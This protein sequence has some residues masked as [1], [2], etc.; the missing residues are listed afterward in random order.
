MTL[1]RLALFLCLISLFVAGL[2]LVDAIPFL[3]GGYGWQWPYALAPAGRIA[4]LAGAL[5]LYGLGL[6]ALARRQARDRWWLA[7]SVCAVAGLALAVLALRADEVLYELFARTVSPLSTGVYT[8]AARIDW[9]GGAWRDWPA[10]MTAFE[11]EIAHVS[12]APPGLPLL[13][14]LIQQVFAW[15]PGAAQPIYRLLLPYQCHNYALLA[16]A[17]FVWASAIFGMLL[18][19][20]AA[21]GALPLYAAARRASGPRTARLAVALYPLVPA[22]LVFSGTWNSVYPLIG[23]LALWALLRGL[24]AQGRRWMFAG[25]GWFALTGLITGLAIF[26]NFAFI[27]LILLAGWLTLLHWWLVERRRGTAAPW[28]APLL[29]GAWFALGLA[30]PWLLY[31]LASGQ[32]L[33]GLLATSL[34]MHLELDRPYLPWVWLHFWDWVLWAGLPLAL[35]WLAGL[36][37]GWRRGKTPPVLALALL[38]TIALLIVSNFARGETGRVWLLFAPMLLI[39]AADGMLRLN[40][41]WRWLLIAQAGWLLAVAATLDAVGT[42]LTPPPD[43][44]PALAFDQPSGANFDDVFRLDGWTAQSDAAGIDLALTWTPLAR[45]ERP[46]W[47]SA[48]VVDAAGAP[49]GPAR[50]WQP[51]DTRYPTTCWA[52]GAALTDAVRLPLP[53]DARGPFWISLSAFGDEDGTDRL[54]VT[55]PDG[56]QDTQVGLG[57]VG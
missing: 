42:G 40:G 48:L 49:V 44:P 12:L 17:P 19:L 8:A 31:G 5:A 15:L 41:R 45:A 35:L 18:P 34:S 56:A 2:L 24:D 39:A 43:A 25:A 30:L 57:P 7:W 27:P 6:W 23:G 33:F 1:R 21:L 52:P 10:L 32:T 47:F 20:W 29:R 14:A 37:A 53:D 50:D 28:L 54:P 38:L 3:R 16:D 55:L 22:L 26:I 51:F 46:Y 11:G 13:Y 4:L 9:A 36:L